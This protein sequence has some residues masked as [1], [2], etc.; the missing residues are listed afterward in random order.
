MQR[1][2]MP[3]TS[4]NDAD[5]TPGEV[6]P[7]LAGAG[8]EEQVDLALEHVRE[9]VAGRMPLLEVPGGRVAEHGEHATGRQLGTIPPGPV[10]VADRVGPD[11]EIVGQ[12][13][14]VRGRGDRERI[15]HAASLRLVRGPRKPQATYICA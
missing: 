5:L 4:G 9:L 14:Q 13:D 1:H 6:E 3:A 8:V 7:P 10:P 2:A 15:G 12:V 11:A